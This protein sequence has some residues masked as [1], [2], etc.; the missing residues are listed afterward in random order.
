MNVGESERDSRPNKLWRLSDFIEWKEWKSALLYA[1]PIS[2]F[3]LGLFYYWFAVADRYAVFLYEHLGATPFDDVTNGRYWMSGLVASGAVMVGY[4]TMNWLLGRVA[5][6]RQR[7]YH[8]P[9]WQH[10]WLLCVVP[11]VVGLLIITMTLN[12]PTL[13][14]A[15]GLA[16]V[17]A[18]LIGLALALAPGSL[19]AR[20]P[21]DLVWLTFDG[22]GLMPSL[23]LLRTV[24]LPSRGL[25]DVPVAY[26]VALGSTFAGAAWLSVMTVLRVWRRQSPPS[27]GKLFVSGLCLSY[28][29]MPLVHHLFTPL[30]YH[31]I[32]AASNFFASNEG[33]QFGV[34]LVAAILA[35]GTARLRCKVFEKTD[36]RKSTLRG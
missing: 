21:R 18:T 31:Y 2:L 6:L 20:H 28:L 3:V 30:E 29:L 35:I 34:F 27:L 10:V 9:M 36:C 33:V 12:W 5:V 22:V 23:L 19:A 16:C 15:N 25:L 17:A 4:V 13:P 26:M 32:S 8:P 1:G 7:E 11:L 24:E 14:L